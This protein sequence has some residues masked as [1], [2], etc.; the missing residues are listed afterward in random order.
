MQLS[1]LIVKLQNIQDE[2]GDCIVEIANDCT[3][4][5]DTWG[6]DR[7]CFFKDGDIQLAIIVEE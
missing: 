4:V 7:V 3:S 5:L 6:I 1:D 2:Y